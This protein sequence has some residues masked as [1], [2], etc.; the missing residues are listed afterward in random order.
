MK[1]KKLTR[2]ESFLSDIS[3]D[4]LKELYKKK[5][6]AK[7]MDMLLTYIYRKD[8]KSIREIGKIPPARS[9]LPYVTSWFV[10][11]KQDLID[12]TTYQSPKNSLQRW[13]TR[14]RL[15]IFHRIHQI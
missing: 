8:N 3:I 13:T 7:A 14:P 11:I 6:D 1:K 12:S 4:K 10:Q 5:T 9:T 15:C 2:G